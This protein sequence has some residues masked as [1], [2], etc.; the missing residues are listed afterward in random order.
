MAEIGDRR[1]LA[2]FWARRDLFATTLLIL[3]LDTFGNFDDEKNDEEA[4][5]LDWS[6]ETVEMEIRETTG[7]DIDPNSFERL[8][9]AIAIRTTD[10][11]FQ[12]AG[13][14]ARACVV[15]SGDRVEGA[16]LVFPD[17]ADA[18]WGMTEGLLLHPPAN[19]DSEPFSAEIAAFIGVCLDDEGILHPP[20][21]LR[22]G[23]R[24]TKL[25]DRA[26]YEFSD[27]PEMFSA[28]YKFEDDKTSTINNTITGRTVAL[29][30]QL[31]ELPLQNGQ[32][33]FAEK[34]LARLPQVAPLPIG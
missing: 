24:S 12:H 19:N 20:D 7:V 1:N 26:R 6:P 34:M 9:T 21:V 30:H 4:A 3:F 31:R 18:A 2:A 16:E 15:L 13:D 32:V 14:F 5:P 11:F 10:N 33:D 22:I 27:D 23:L 28:I 29:L 17:C 25:A 8:M